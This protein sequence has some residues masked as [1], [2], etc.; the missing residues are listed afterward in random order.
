MNIDNINERKRIKKL[1]RYIAEG[2]LMRVIDILEV[3][4]HYVNVK[5]TK[6]SKQHV[7]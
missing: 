2:S 1:Q 4:P 6:V 5:T 3:H 7:T